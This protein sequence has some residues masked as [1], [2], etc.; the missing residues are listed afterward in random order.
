VTL[1]IQTEEDEKRQMMMT[2]EVPEDR[3]EKEMKRA[4]RR[5]AREVHIPGF[6][7]GKAPYGVVLRRVGRDTLR[8][9]V[10]EDMVQPVLEEAVEQVEVEIYGPPSLDDLELEPLVLKFTVPLPPQVTLGDFRELRQE[11]EPIEI[12]EEAVEEAL[13]QVRVRHQIVDEVDR[14]AQ[15]GD[16][17]S[18]SG[19]GELVAE[20]DAAEETETTAESETDGD[21]SKDLPESS[22]IFDE[23]SIDLLM[24]SD[25]LFVGTDFVDNMI[26]LSAGDDKSFSIDFP[27]DYEDEDLSGRSATISIS[28]LN[29]KSRELPV[30]DDDLAKTEA[31]HET[32][33]ELRKSVR[34]NLEERAKTDSKNALIESMVDNLLEDAELVYPPAAVE[35]EIDGMVESFQAQVTRSGW[36]WEDYLK[37][38]GN[39]E[40]K[41]RDDFRERATESLERRLALRQFILEE[42]LTVDEADVDN[43]V[44]ERI[45]TFSD[46]EALKESME[47]YYRSGYGLDIISSEILMD[48]AYHR[49][50]EIF[51]GNAPDLDELDRAESDEEE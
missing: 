31:G 24:D 17:V 27:E 39:A 11:I 49:I 50:T 19:R 41:I 6:R 46:N 25:K 22:I 47:K 14:P 48:K 23:E 30:L 4:A 15:P 16:I 43:A 21:V 1:T 26:G 37:L 18:V 20:E 35:L 12:T 42:K 32:L 34:D 28:V 2:V 7:R 3:V 5:L 8:T 38:Q 40:E 51:V 13:E 10:I 45:G 29:V 33:E 9:D 44:E 36:E